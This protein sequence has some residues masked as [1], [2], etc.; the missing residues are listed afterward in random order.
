MYTKFLK[1]STIRMAKP[2]VEQNLEVIAPIINILAPNLWE[3]CLQGIQICRRNLYSLL[4]W[5]T[6]V[7]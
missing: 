1:F 2:C 4:K 5:N 7:V 3:T 6:N